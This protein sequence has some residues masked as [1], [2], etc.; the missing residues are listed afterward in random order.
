[1]SRAHDT[2]YIR[3]LA[4]GHVSQFK[5]CIGYEAGGSC[6][7]LDSFS[8]AIVKCFYRKE[9]FALLKNIRPLS[10]CQQELKAT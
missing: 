2:K 7:K 1:M 5:V 6:M 9:T 8:A 3:Q 10:E 4:H